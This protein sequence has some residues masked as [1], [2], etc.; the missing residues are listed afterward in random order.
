MILSIVVIGI[1]GLTAYLWSARGLFSALIH[2][3]C[4]LVAGAI[5]FGLW[6][7]LAYGV[8]MGVREDMAFALGLAV[9]FIVALLVLRL[10]ADA[11]L[12]KNMAFDDVTNFVGG[13]LFGALS[14]VI[15]TGI[16][17]T[18]GGYLRLP[19][20]VFGYEAAQ[21]DAKGSVV[22]K[23][24]L[25]LP[26]DR[27]TVGLYEM[28]STGSMASETPLALRVPEAYE[29]AAAARLTYGG[30]GRTSISPG[31]AEVVGRYVVGGDLDLTDASNPQPQDVLGV[32]GKPFPPGSRLE[33]YVVRLKAG[34]KEKDGQFAVSPGM[35]RLVARTGD[36]AVALHPIAVISRSAPST[37]EIKRWRFDARDVVI[38]S[39]GGAS[40]ATFAF[41]FVVPKDAT[42]RDLYVRSV[43]VDA[44]GAPAEFASRAAR[45]EAIASRSGIF[46][47]VATGAKVDAPAPAPGA[48]AASPEPE[49]AAIRVSDRFGGVL[50]KSNRGSLEIDS[51]NRIIDGDHSFEKKE[52][53]AQGIDVNLRMESFATSADVNIVQVDVSWGRRT[54]LF[55]KAFDRALEVLPPVLVDNLG[56]QYQAVGFIYDT[57]ATVRMRFTPGSPIRALK[58]IPQLSASKAGER[59]IL[60]FRPSAGV[61]IVKF[62]L[63]GQ[64]IEQLNPPINVRPGRNLRR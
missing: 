2:F 9:P 17:V 44:P 30:K 36:G 22:R 1:V 61:D 23:T 55:G 25:L 45:D 26:V 48:Q 31:D 59:L 56:Q 20:S 54:S 33:G 28:M 62:Q 60:L 49:G 38:S 35:F 10:G 43:R 29:G 50:N 4:T 34:A 8:F 37:L 52:F 6:E 13:L 5:A 39:V 46:E 16:V 11:L 24:G 14:A 41:E 12:R 47:K 53:N 27:I 40:D 58:E 51:D 19:P 42:D 32:D 63:G 3:V 15:A 7:P 21:Y 57:G 18:A 64:V